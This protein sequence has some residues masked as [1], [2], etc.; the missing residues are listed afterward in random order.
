MAVEAEGAAPAGTTDGGRPARVGIVT[1]DGAEL[2]GR[3]GHFTRHGVYFGGA[4]GMGG[5]RLPARRR[6][7]GG[8]VGMTAEDALYGL[9]EGA[10][11]AV[12]LKEGCSDSDGSR[13]LFGIVER[14]GAFALVVRSRDGS[15][16][17]TVPWANV[18]LV[19]EDMD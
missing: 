9:A 1:R 12:V 15:R 8:G 10:D 13:L 3:L 18:A 6:P 11:V 5:L 19:D 16:R 17:R 4:D 7:P 2:E 14:E